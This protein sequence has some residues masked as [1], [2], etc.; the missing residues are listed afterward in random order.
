MRKKSTEEFKMQLFEKYPNIKVLSEYL[1]SKKK[2]LLGCINGHSWEAIPDKLLSGD[3]SGYRCRICEGVGIRAKTHKQFCEDVI[4]KYPHIKVLGTYTRSTEKVLIGSSICDHTWYIAPNTLLSK[5]F[6]GICRICAP[7]VHIKKQVDNINKEINKQKRYTEI[8]YTLKNKYN[9][10]LISNYSGVRK[11][12]TL[13]CDNGHTW[14]TSNIGNLLYYGTYSKC[15]IC[16]PTNISMGE[17]ELRDFIES[18]YPGWIE[19]NNR[20]ILNNNLELDIVLPD[21]GI[22]FEYN[23]EYYHDENHRGKLFHLNKTEEVN[24]FGYRLIHIYENAWKHKKDIV[25]SRISSILGLSYKIGARKCVVKEIP[26]PKE[27]L[28]TNHIQ[29]SGSPTKYNYGLYFSDELVAVM[30]FN[31]PRF[32]K[33]YTYELVRFC[34]LLD[35]NV[36]GGAS[37]LLKFFRETNIGSIISYADRSWSSGTLYEKLGFFYLY[38]TEP[39]YVYHKGG[40]ILNRYACQKHKL[41]TLFPEIY[42]EELTEHS[43]MKIAGYTP[44]YDSGS[45]V[46]ILK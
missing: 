5:G 42:S 27:F 2:I 12:A 25:K 30:T 11:S 43:I 45:M 37:K 41:K 36:V 8:K 44:V 29:G 6:G 1:G 33:D 28:E 31:T 10:N 39:N 9:L 3:P 26:F 14:I 24:A 22:A 15:P 20:E 18:R 16:N 19:Y 23:G 7:V 4:N 13:Q 46:W 38:N 35:I 40:N 17:K 34:S 32:S 21:L